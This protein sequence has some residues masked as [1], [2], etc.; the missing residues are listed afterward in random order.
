MRYASYDLRADPEVVLDAVDEYPR[1]LAYAHGAALALCADRT[2]V[3]A[4]VRKDGR[5]LRYASYDLRAD[6]AVVLDAVQQDPL[7]L[8]HARGAARADRTVVLAA[9]R[10]DGHVH[11]AEIGHGSLF[12][13]AE[14]NHTSVGANAMTWGD[15]ACKSP[16]GT[17][18]HP[19]PLGS[20]SS[21]LRCRETCSV[22]RNDVFCDQRS[23]GAELQGEDVRLG[24][25]N[26]CG[27]SQ[28]A[29]QAEVATVMEREGLDVLVLTET[30]IVEA[31]SNRRMMSKGGGMW[32]AAADLC[33]Q[34]IWLD[35]LRVFRWRRGCCGSTEP[36][37]RTPPTVSRTDA[38]G[39]V[40]FSVT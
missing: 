39:C 38:N 11:F 40:R 5:A 30:R 32:C 24:T 1:A 28:P 21:S 27:L 18:A 36:M 33:V 6:P 8:V 23:S 7:A 25:L 14:I 3:L 16:Q 29:K 34:A 20:V 10:K 37:I 13:G 19:C 31:A 35:G 22:P 4:A 15:P 26:V 17:I 9:V 12:V 2:V